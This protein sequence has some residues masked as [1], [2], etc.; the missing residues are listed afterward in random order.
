MFASLIVVAI[1][2]LVIVSFIARYISIAKQFVACKD[3]NAEQRVA[4][5]VR[6]ASDAARRQ[7]A[8][9][10]AIASYRITLVNR[11]DQVFK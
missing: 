5:A 6:Y 3:A 10:D 4:Q 11:A 9:E 1:V 8:Y 7:H 2:L